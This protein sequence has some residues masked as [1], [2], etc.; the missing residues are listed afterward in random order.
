MHAAVD[1][2]YKTEPSIYLRTWDCILILTVIDVVIFGETAYEWSYN[3]SEI[4]GRCIYAIFGV[5]AT[6]KCN[7]VWGNYMYS[8]K[9]PSVLIDRVETFKASYYYWYE[10][11]MIGNSV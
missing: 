4:D 2:K 5:L 7:F 11:L 8:R 6:Y 1:V 10:L 9:R 3:Y